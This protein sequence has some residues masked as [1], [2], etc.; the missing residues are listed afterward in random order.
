LGD[1]ADGPFLLFERDGFSL[2][3]GGAPGEHVQIATRRTE[4]QATEQQP[5]NADE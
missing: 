3:R 1:L 5:P 2:P 4:Q